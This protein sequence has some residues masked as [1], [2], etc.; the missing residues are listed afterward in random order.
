VG[1]SVA[2]SVVARLQGIEGLG[3]ASPGE[4][5]VSLWIRLAIRAY[6]LPYLRRLELPHKGQNYHQLTLYNFFVSNQTK[7]QTIGIDTQARMARGIHGLP[8]VLPGPAMPD[9]LVQMHLT[10]RQCLVKKMKCLVTIFGNQTIWSGPVL[11]FAV[12]FY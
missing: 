5:I 3:M 2:I 12:N 11:I 4:T 7:R 9:R 8:K 10:T 1:V 6:L